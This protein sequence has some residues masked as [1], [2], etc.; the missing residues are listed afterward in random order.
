MRGEVTLINP[1][2]GMAALVT[3]N[4]EY[5]S[6]ELLGYD[7]EIGD[8]IRGD[9]ESVGSETWYKE[10]QMEKIEVMVEDIYGSRQTALSIIS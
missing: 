8:I 2:R 6:F 10:T 3:E 5:T 1:K 4:E 7:V 9:L